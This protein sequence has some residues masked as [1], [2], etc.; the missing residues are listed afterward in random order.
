LDSEE[1]AL[2][3]AQA[4]Q[5]AA[6]DAREL[7]RQVLEQL[8]FGEQVPRY[9]GYALNMNTDPIE[10]V[11]DVD[12]AN[13][14]VRSTAIINFDLAVP[15]WVGWAGRAPRQSSQALRVQ[16]RQFIVAPWIVDRVEI[17]ADGGVMPAPPGG[18]QVAVVRFKSVQQFMS[19]NL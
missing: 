2:H 18:L 10:D 14:V 8:Q 17:S 5:S 3:A 15:V 13:G 11:P 19:G 4:A 12:R 6:V 9:E 16:P 7:L 1:S